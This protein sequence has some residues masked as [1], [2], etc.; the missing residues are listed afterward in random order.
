VPHVLYHC[1]LTS[2]C[3]LYCVYQIVHYFLLRRYVSVSTDTVFMEPGLTLNSF[4]ISDDCKHLLTVRYTKVIF[5]NH[6]YT[7]LVIR[8]ETNMW[9]GKH[10]VVHKC[11]LTNGGD[12]RVK[13]V[14]L[15]YIL[16]LVRTFMTSMR[17]LISILVLLPETQGYYVLSC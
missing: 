15:N 17:L 8:A 9:F 2:I 3:A 5:L 7:S 10:S 4:N 13:M 11:W 1:V 6:K 14:C 12:K 16:L